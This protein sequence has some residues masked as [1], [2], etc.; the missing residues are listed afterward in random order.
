MRTRSPNSD[1]GAEPIDIAPVKVHPENECASSV[2][3]WILKLRKDRTCWHRPHF[4]SA[5][6]SPDKINL[7]GRTLQPRPLYPLNRF[8][9]SPQSHI[10]VADN[11]IHLHRKQ[12]NRGTLPKHLP[13]QVADRRPLHL[14]HPHT[15]SAKAPIHVWPEPP[16]HTPTSLLQAPVR[17]LS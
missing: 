3:L 8:R 11:L 4:I 17:Q 6:S 14:L 10:P 15:R 9:L 2:E 12:T 1:V 5:N 13:L 16:R 7:L